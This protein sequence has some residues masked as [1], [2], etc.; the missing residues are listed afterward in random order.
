M[1][2]SSR[3]CGKVG[4]P[5]F[6]REFQA[7]WESRFF[8]FSTVRLFNSPSR[9]G[10]V[11]WQSRTL[12]A[13]SAQTVR[14]VRQTKSSIQ[15]L[16]DGHGA[17]R[18]AGSPA[19]RFDLQAEILNADRVVPVHRALELQREDEIQIPAAARHKGATRLRRPHLKTAV[20]IWHAVLPPGNTQPVPPRV[21]P[22]PPHYRHA[23]PSLAHLTR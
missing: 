5:R 8:D 12:G 10:F 11:F 1:T 21:P 4:I 22:S 7:R 17:A 20:E 6:L 14:S 3:G 16:V 13:V 18:Q 2:S 15:M 9:R 23:P 19:H